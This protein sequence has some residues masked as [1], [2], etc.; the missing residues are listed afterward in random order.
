M[1]VY[2]M[3]SNKNNITKV[4]SISGKNQV[5]KFGQYIYHDAE[6]FLYRKYNKFVEKYTA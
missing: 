4:A 3:L 6:S 1:L 2:I 5:E